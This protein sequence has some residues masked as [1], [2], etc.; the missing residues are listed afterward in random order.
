MLDPADQ[1][2]VDDLIFEEQITIQELTQVIHETIAVV[3]G[4]DWW[5]TLKLLSVTQGESATQILGEMTRY[6]I[7][8]ISLAAWVNG[9]Y[10]L[11]VRYM[12]EEDKIKL[13]SELETPPADQPMELSQATEKATEQA[14][15][16][17]MTQG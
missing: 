14:F 4:H 3:S 16:A 15:M 1:F 7:N 17:M 6:D 5:W 9:L 12:K 10:A 8:H 13:D 11:L 2:I